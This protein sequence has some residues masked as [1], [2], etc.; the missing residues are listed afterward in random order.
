MPRK[1]VFNTDDKNFKL[2]LEAVANNPDFTKTLSMNTGAD[3]E[4]F[5][6]A[7]THSFKDDNNADRDALFKEILAEAKDR[8]ASVF[9]KILTLAFT[10]NKTQE[11]SD[12]DF[13]F[14]TWANMIVGNFDEPGAKPIV[15][16]SYLKTSFFLPIIYATIACKL[17]K[18]N[19]PLNNAQKMPLDIMTMFFDSLADRSH[20]QDKALYGDIMKVYSEKL[21][22]DYQQMLSAN[23]LDK[24]NTTLN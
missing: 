8:F 15:D 16:V 12:V 3:F 22:E 24:N 17:V 6:F 19:I 20:P 13:Y 5:I 9:I 1:F 7:A 2:F 18:E 14:K 21:R 10:N 23:S 4:I 11:F